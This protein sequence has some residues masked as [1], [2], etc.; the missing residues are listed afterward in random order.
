MDPWAEYTEAL[1]ALA[2]AAAEEAEKR[3]QLE[4]EKKSFLAEAEHRVQAR[5][6]E[7][8]SISD[9]LSRV[10]QQV[11][12]F[13]AA[14]DTPVGPA[15]PLAPPTLESIRSLVREADQ[16]IQRAA[17]TRQSLMRS[18]ARLARLPAAPPPPPES[19]PAAGRPLARVVVG[20]LIG[21]VA[22]AVIVVIV[23]LTTRT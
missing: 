2:V 14:S 19:V 16:W 18:K 21:L 10:R 7:F 15:I 23:W 13:V 17:Q 4:A 22:V 6:T 8:Q 3:A 11:D 20:V 1:A 9:Q 5:L 12:A